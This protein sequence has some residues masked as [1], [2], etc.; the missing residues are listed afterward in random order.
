MAQAKGPPHAKTASLTQLPC[1]I[2]YR[3]IL[4]PVAVSPEPRAHLVHTSK[5]VSAYVVSYIYPVMSL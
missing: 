1:P 5:K 2:L 3:L 4:S